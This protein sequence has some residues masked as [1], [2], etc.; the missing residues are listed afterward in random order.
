[1][2][3]SCQGQSEQPRK[4][5][6]NRGGGQKAEAAG[7]SISEEI[8]DV[9]KHAGIGL[10]DL[11]KPTA[12][13]RNRGEF[14]SLDIKNLGEESSCGAELPSFVHRATTLSAVEV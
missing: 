2:A 14:L 1:M 9:P 5:N 10:V 13:T 6:Y 11:R 7:C 3:M 12:R 4:G 8:K